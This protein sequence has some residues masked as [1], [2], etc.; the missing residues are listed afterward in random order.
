MEF[1][2]PRSI[3]A[4]FV[5]FFLY[6]PLCVCFF[7]SPRWCIANTWFIKIYAFSDFICF[8]VFILRLWKLQTAVAGGQRGS[9]AIQAA[10]TPHNSM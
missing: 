8:R 6:F 2:V 3:A 1:H 10:Q 9:H 7:N 4:R 5:R